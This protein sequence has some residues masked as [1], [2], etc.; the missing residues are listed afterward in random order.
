MNK[1][2]LYFIFLF[3]ALMGKPLTRLYQGQDQDERDAADETLYHP[4][5]VRAVIL[6]SSLGD[7]AV[8]PPQRE[9]LLSD[10]EWIFRNPRTQINCLMD[11]W[12]FMTADELDQPHGELAT[13]NSS[14]C[15]T[16]TELFGRAISSVF[17]RLAAIYQAEGVLRDGNGLDVLFYETDPDGITITG[18]WL[19]QGSHINN[20]SGVEANAYDRTDTTHHSST[21]SYHLV[22][23]SVRRDKEIVVMAHKH[24]YDQEPHLLLPTNEHWLARQ[25]EYL[26]PY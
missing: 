20:F 6:T 14:V 5:N 10:L 8:P 21:V 9:A 23:R 3:E 1:I 13:Y 2:K 17:A 4:T 7:C 12:K 16:T 25:P 22:P 26:R 24:L 18:A 15:F 11:S 19:F